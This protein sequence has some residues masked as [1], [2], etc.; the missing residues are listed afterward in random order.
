MDINV[1]V[2]ATN[3]ALE[4]LAKEVSKNMNVLYWYGKNKERN[5]FTDAC[6]IVNEEI[7]SER[8]KCKLSGIREALKAF[9]MEFIETEDAILFCVRSTGETLCEYRR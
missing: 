4:T 2:V 5:T 3:D 8:A 7:K 1:T 9:N 6:D